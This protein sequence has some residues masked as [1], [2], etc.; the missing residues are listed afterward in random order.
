LHLT[1][2]DIKQM[3]QS[4]EL[5]DC[6]SESLFLWSANFFNRLCVVLLMKPLVEPMIEQNGYILEWV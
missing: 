1:D 2:M 3:V 5:K 6:V 4:V